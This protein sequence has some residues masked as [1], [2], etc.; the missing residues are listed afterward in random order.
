MKTVIKTFLFRVFDFLTVPV[1]YLLLPILGLIRRFGIKHFPL[2]K[3]AFIRRGVFPIRNHYYEPQFV[4][5]AAFEAD[6]RRKL[7]LDL[8]EQEQLAFLS[9]LQYIDELKQFK[10]EEDGIGR[11]FY[12]NNPAFGPGDADMYYLLIR[13]SKPRRIIEIGS[14]FST[15]AAVEAIRRNSE[16]GVETTITCIEPYEMDWLTSI[17]E[18]KLI[19]Q[20]VEKTDLG[21]FASLEENDIL[22]IDSSHIIRPEN[23][24]LFEFL[25]ILPV[26]KKGVFVHIHDIFTPRHYRQDWLTEE[27]RFWNEQYLLEAFLYYNRSFQVIASLNHLKT[28]YY[29]DT[30][31]VLIH[32]TPTSEPASFWLKKVE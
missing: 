20:K 19:K 27:F 7:H 10:K 16:E 13:N 5:S 11:S 30:S 21:M 32:L 14:G 1:V 15:L 17:P 18:V 8:K 29:D 9:T 22:F 25:E 12:V 28:E 31:K 24:V 23:D 3:A 4:F 26:L 2:N 6:K